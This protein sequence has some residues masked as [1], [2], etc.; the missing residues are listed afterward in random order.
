MKHPHPLILSKSAKDRAIVDSLFNPINGQT[1]ACVESE[2]FDLGKYR[3][4]LVGR[5]IPEH[6]LPRVAI[7]WSE[8]RNDSEGPYWA[9]FCLPMPRE[10][11]T[12]P[13][14]ETVGASNVATN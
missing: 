11:G 6:M 4:S 3:S 2:R 8:R 9:L 1:L 10:I 7:V 14:C 5:T 13:K 12:A